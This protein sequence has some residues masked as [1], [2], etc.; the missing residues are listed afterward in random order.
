M[1]KKK[2]ARGNTPRTKRMNKEGR[3]Q[4]AAVWLKRY[5]GTH[6]LRD[7]CTRYAVDA[8]TA[9]LELTALGVDIPEKTA[10][11]IRRKRK[12]AQQKGAE[13]QRR[14]KVERQD[15]PDSD[16]TYA[17][18]AGYTAWGFPYG[19]TWEEME[20]MADEQSL[21]DTVPPAEA[22]EQWRYTTHTEEDESLF[23]AVPPV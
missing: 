1:G 6:I 18:I 13:K 21:F 15:L 10:A 17:F 12:L 9:L 20:Q 3:K 23:A 11:C 4:S 16:E 8:Y 22:D 14:R 19:L 5:A 7:Y 2:R